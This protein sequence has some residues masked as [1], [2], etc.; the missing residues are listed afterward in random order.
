M[1]SIKNYL[2]Q[3]IC[4]GLTL[5]VIN[6]NAQVSYEQNALTKLEGY[7]NFSYKSIYREKEYNINTTIIQQKDIFQKAAEDKTF[8]YLFTMETL[9]DENKYP[10]TEV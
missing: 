4:F 8:G 9:T 10:R 7:K 5:F 1:I 6:A 3:S 2:K